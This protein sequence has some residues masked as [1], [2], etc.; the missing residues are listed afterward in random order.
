[1]GQ[2]QESEKLDTRQTIV[3]SCALDGE[4]YVHLKGGQ[5]MGVPRWVLQTEWVL[6]NTEKERESFAWTRIKRVRS[7][8]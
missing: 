5:K 2:D 3:E 8:I 4:G 7:W 6:H 1:M